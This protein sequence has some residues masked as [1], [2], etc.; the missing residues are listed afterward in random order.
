MRLS[1]GPVC[2]ENLVAH[3]GGGGGKP[4]GR[5]IKMTSGQQLQL[6]AAA[7]EVSKTLMS[8]ETGYSEM[9]TDPSDVMEM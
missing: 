1:P 3:P 7:G 8:E 9:Y 5:E 2:S 4:T 6:L